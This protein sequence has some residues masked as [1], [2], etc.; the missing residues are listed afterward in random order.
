MSETAVQANMYFMG[1][2]RDGVV[3]KLSHLHSGYTGFPKGEM[4]KYH[5]HDD[6]RKGP[7][8]RDR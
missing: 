4:E 2:S 6:R 8:I 1:E 3:E 7:D 5:V